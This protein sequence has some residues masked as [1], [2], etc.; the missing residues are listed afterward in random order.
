MIRV[1][2]ALTLLTVFIAG[3]VGKGAIVVIEWLL[4][5]ALIFIGLRIL[6]RNG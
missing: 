5:A 6:S 3:G 1:V 2:L 4:V